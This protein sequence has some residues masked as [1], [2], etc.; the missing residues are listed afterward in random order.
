MYVYGDLSFVS[1]N[2]QYNASYPEA[3]CL[4]RRGANRGL[5]IIAAIP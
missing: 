1:V 2:K 3:S 5:I 4:V